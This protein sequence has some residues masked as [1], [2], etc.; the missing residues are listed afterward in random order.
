MTTE[1]QNQKRI[2]NTI[3]QQLGGGRFTAMTGSKH[4]VAMK[5]GLGM[6]LRRN[7]SGANYLR[8]TLNSMDTYDMEF[9]L[10]TMKS[11]KTK[12]LCEGIYDD[13]L[14]STFREQTGLNTNL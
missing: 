6:K 13:M 9:M 1:T 12:A 4:Y 7:T 14:A 10:I 3:L 8:I 5:S 11:M 2:A